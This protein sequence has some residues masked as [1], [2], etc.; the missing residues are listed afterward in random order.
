LKEDLRVEHAGRLV[1]HIAACSVVESQC[2]SKLL[3]WVAELE[4]HALAAGPVV[5]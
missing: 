4:A 1:L 3:W 2:L 5:E